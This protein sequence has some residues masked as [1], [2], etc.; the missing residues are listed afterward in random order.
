VQPAQG[1]GI[2]PL[3]LSHLTPPHFVF[4]IYSAFTLSCSLLNSLNSIVHMINAISQN[5][6]GGASEGRQVL[7]AGP[8]FS[9]SIWEIWC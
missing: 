9:P 7:K 8:E 1:L 4:S 5:W 2:H 3:E 6:K